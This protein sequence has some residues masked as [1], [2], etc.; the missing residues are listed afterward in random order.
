MAKNKISDLRDHLFETLEA[1]KDPDKPMELDRA[2]AISDVAQVII[3]VA[4]V[5]VD[6]VKAVGGEAPAD[7]FFQLPPADRD[8]AKHARAIDERKQI[9]ETKKAG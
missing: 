8:V 9:G 7:G 1:L 5:E 4:K 3:N 2:K 6:M